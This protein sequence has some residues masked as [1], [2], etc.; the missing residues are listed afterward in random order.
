MRAE[1]VDTVNCPNCAATLIAGL[2]FCRMC[3]YRLGEGVEEYVA[4]QRLDSAAPLLAAPSQATDPFAARQTWGAQSLQPLGTTSLR[5]QQRD[6]S[7]S[8]SRTS[9][10]NP[11]R[12]GWLTWMILLIVLLTASGVITKS[13]RNR[14]AGGDKRNDTGVPATSLADEADAYDTADGGGA[15]IRG[16]AG[17]DTSLERAGLVGGDIIKSFDGQTVG[18]GDAMRRLIAATPPGKPVPVVYVHDDETKS[19]VLTTTGR[20]GFRGMDSLRQRAGG[21]G[22]LDVDFGDGDRVRVPNSN[23]YGVELTGVERNGP[24]DLAG[25]KKGDI[26]V[27]FDGKPIR[28]AGDLRYRAGAATPGSNVNVVV[29][30]DG[31]QATIPV[32]MGRQ[33]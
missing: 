16:L 14:I 17:P 31:Q 3:G 22:V 10:C 13:V 30:R 19:T 32:K 21:R 9:A 23:I 26:V 5:Q 28:T 11:K 20:E 15:F 18:D 29:V 7:P 6:A 8:W 2:R 4:T 25:L 1:N 12:A 27:E 24:A 33:R